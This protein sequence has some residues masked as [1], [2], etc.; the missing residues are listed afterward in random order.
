MKTNLKTSALAALGYLAGQL[1]SVLAKP[2]G[3]TMGL[4]WKTVLVLLLRALSLYLRGWQLK[5]EKR[6]QKVTAQLQSRGIL[7]ALRT[8][9]GLGP[10]AFNLLMVLGKPWLAQLRAQPCIFKSRMN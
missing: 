4:N 6:L 5:T 3:K 7:D 10:M 2:S 9:G 1:A 8:P